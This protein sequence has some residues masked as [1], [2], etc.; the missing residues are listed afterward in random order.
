MTTEKL[1]VK[2]DNNLD[3]VCICDYNRKRCPTEAKPEC[4]LYLVK[5]I[6]MRPTKVELDD[7]TKE[8]K[9]LKEKVRRETKKVETELH[10][11]IRKMKNFKI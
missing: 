6:E 4:K 9:T 7:K 2:F 5:F 1:W 8:L 10:K 11:S 3:I